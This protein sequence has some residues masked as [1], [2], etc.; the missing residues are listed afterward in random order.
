MGVKLVVGAYG[1]RRDGK[2]VGPF[3]D[4]TNSSCGSSEAFPLEADHKTYTPDG[5]YYAAMG[6]NEYDIVEITYTPGEE[7]RLCDGCG[8]EVRVPNGFNSEGQCRVCLHSRVPVA[9]AEV[10]S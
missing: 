4:N 1:R 3:I 7:W 10:V 5:Q 2:I 9:S 6:E 8:R